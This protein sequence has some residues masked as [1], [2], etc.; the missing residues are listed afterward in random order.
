MI[1]YFQFNIEYL[2]N[3]VNY[4]DDEAKR[5]PQYSIFNFQ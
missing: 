5:H 2:W 1:E 4:K 3:S